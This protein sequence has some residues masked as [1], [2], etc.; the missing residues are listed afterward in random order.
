MMNLLNWDDTRIFLALARAGTLSEAA[1]R[2][3]AVRQ[4]SRAESTGWNARSGF[5]FSCA[6]KAAIG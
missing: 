2:L 6:I 4:P 5:R 1:Q 3:G